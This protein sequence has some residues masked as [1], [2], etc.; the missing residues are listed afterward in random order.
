MT[1][2]SSQPVKG[3]PCPSCG[4]QTQRV[5]RHFIDRLLSLFVPLVRY[6]CR[7]IRCGWEGRL[8]RLDEP[9]RSKVPQPGKQVLESSRMHDIERPPQNRR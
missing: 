7:S 4:G 2:Y 8:K 3:R 9:P 1:A 6:R 5:Q